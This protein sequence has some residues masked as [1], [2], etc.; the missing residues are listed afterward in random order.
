MA[1]TNDTT[2]GVPESHPSLAVRSVHL[3]ILNSFLWSTQS[4][5]QP[6]EQQ[7]HLNDGKT[8]LKKNLHANFEN[9]LTAQM[10]SR[11]HRAGSHHRDQWLPNLL[12]TSKATAQL[13]S[14]Q[15]L[16]A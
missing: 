7:Q 15:T 6:K 1:L 11:T 14:T 9:R 8:H 10:E 13:K 4:S 3:E 16:R 12:S 5:E 2:Y